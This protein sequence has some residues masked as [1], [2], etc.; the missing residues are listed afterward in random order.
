MIVFDNW[1]WR[2]ARNTIIWSKKEKYVEFSITKYNNPFDLNYIS[3][4]FQDVKN[5]ALR[6]LKRIVR[7]RSW[8]ELQ[9]D[10]KTDWIEMYQTLKRF[11]QR[12]WDLLS[13]KMRSFQEH[14]KSMYYPFITS[15]FQIYRKIKSVIHKISNHIQNITFS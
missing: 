3:F 4:I 7:I 11:F 1:N 14:N 12:S 5:V 6:H 15:S 13:P 9:Y 8:K 10:I 2:Y